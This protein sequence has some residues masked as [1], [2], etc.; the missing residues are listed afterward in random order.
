MKRRGVLQVNVMVFDFTVLEF[1]QGIRTDVLAGAAMFVS[2][3]CNKILIIAVF[4]FLFWCINKKHAYGLAMSFVFSGL[5][6]QG[7]KLVFAVERPFVRNKNILPY[8]SALESATGYSFPSG[9]TQTA[10]SLLVYSAFEAKRRVYKILCVA[11]VF[12]VMLSRLVLGVHTP[13]D[14]IV[15]FAVTSVVCFIAAKCPF[16][17]EIG[18][19]VKTL[20]VGCGMSLA[21]FLIAFIKTSSGR[22]PFSMAEDGFETAVIAFA[23]FVFHYIETNFIGFD[24]SKSF[25]KGKAAGIAVKFL[26]G[27]LGVLV[28]YGTVGVVEN[29]SG[30][31]AFAVKNIKNVVVFFWACCVYPIIIKKFAKYG[32]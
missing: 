3:L 16:F 29:Y 18:N 9:H 15:S 2:G 24:C 31:L 10:A 26:L 12:A 21:V 17:D 8:E 30:D 13:S 28:L 6:T 14:V 4:C 22:V 32:A 7:L 23:F 20:L 1:L 5:I 11:V 19:S 27:I 25:V